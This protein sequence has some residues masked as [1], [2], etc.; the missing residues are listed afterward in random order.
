MGLPR[1][2]G[3]VTGRRKRAYIPGARREGDEDV[4]GN[5]LWLP[6]KGAP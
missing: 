2:W 4:G 5:P 3:F 6:N 1:M